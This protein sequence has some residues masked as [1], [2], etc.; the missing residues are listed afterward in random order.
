MD[1]AAGH[2]AHV[3]ERHTAL[4]N[5][6]DWNPSGTIL[7]AAMKDKT[8]LL[9]DVIT[10]TELRVLDLHKY[11]V[12]SVAWSPD[13]K[14]LAGLFKVSRPQCIQRDCQ[15]SYSSQKGSG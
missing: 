15:Y 3:F 10:G 13:G 11:G 1:A 8:I 9:W 4:V 14:M 2:A 6:L 12:N 5:D 7:A